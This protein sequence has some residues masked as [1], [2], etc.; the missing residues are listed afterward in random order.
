MTRAAPAPAIAHQRSRASRAVRAAACIVL[1]LVPV[2]C[3]AA[4]ARKSETRPGPQQ[5]GQP[6]ERLGED[7][8]RR[9]ADAAAGA[10]ELLSRYLTIDTSNPPGNEI[11]GARFLYD[12]L[13]ADG[14]EAQIFE[15]EPGRGN[16]Y[17]RLPGAGTKR[18][19]LLLNH[20]DV[21][22]ANPAEWRHDPYRG[23]VAEGLV[24]GRGAL[25][26]K[27]V[28]IVQLLSLVALK[29]AGVELARD[30]IF[31]AT[32]DEETG[33]RLGTGWFVAEHFNLIRDVEFVLNE[34]GFIHRSDRMPL[35]FNVN[36]AEKA[37]CWFRV[38]AQGEP[39]HASRPPTQ[40]AV[41]RLV[42][43]LHRLTTWHL[44]LEVGPIV[45]G[46]Y[47]AYAQL[48]T[49]NA[50]YY[51]E[52]AHSLSNETE[53][54]HAFLNDPAAA[55]LVRDTITPTVLRAS[56]KT[57]VVPAT[58]WAEVD[59][60][61]LPGHECDRFLDSVRMRIGDEQVRV[62]PAGVSF[63]ATQSPID[64]EL[65]AAVERAAA[66]ET[67]DAVVLAGLLTGFTDSH[68]FRD[69]GIAAYGFSPIEASAEQRQAIHGPDENVDV[70][71]L[72]RGVRRMTTILR[73]LS[74]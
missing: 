63:P 3:P 47:S 29:R 40:T 25:D 49:A 20:I 18:P 70:A 22:P 8:E 73:E 6:L 16:V 23:L 11:A 66:A 58:A 61:L 24:Y 37:P 42:A 2:S 33:G 59:S 5:A 41:T 46:Y 12:V 13:V 14:I 4:E 34:G 54:R 44:P 7:A 57:N 52:L 51:R 26:C 68:W 69:R 19:V 21:V 31:L 60:R 55:A 45:A 65:M 43:A 17:A 72:E 10:S 64:S 27:G 53:F 30:V 1:V 35:V 71:A 9:I 62:E 50:R 28:G 39:G 74:R 32:A 36:A 38:V 56:P 15:S 48:D 67:Q